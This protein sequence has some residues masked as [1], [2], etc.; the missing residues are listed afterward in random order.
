M[1]A[2]LY[3]TPEALGLLAFENPDR[4]WQVVG[5]IPMVEFLAQSGNDNSANEEK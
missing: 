4:P 1:H 5:R 2:L 3:F